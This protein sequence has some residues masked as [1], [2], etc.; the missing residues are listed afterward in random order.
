LARLHRELRI[1]TVYVTHDQGEAL[2]LADRVVVMKDGRIV[3][4]GTPDDLYWRPSDTF[5][6]GFIGSPGMNLWTVPWTDDGEGVSLGG[7]LWLPRDVL[8]VLEAIGPT[9]TV[10]IRPEHLACSTE[11]GR[12][13]VACRAELVE[14]LGSHVQVH[15]RLDNRQGD[16]QRLV[17][18]LDATTDV[19]AGRDLLLSA[20]LSGVHLFHPATG[21]RV[22]TGDHLAGAD[23]PAGLVGVGAAHASHNGMGRSATDLRPQSATALP[24]RVTLSVPAGRPAGAVRSG[25]T[26]VDLA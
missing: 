18:R 10:G 19:A 4:V 25:G 16:G 14:R 3:Q 22:D 6:A 2:T 7:A 20:P 23:V 9:V 11:G 21:R 26:R 8:P 24:S 12:G 17:A 5:V 1:T 15:A 13:E